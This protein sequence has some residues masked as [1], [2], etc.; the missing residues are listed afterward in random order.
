MPLL[1]ELVSHDANSVSTGIIIFV[2]SRWSKGYATW[3]CCSCDAIGISISIMWCQWH[4]RWHHCICLVKIIKTKCNIGTGIGIKNG[5]TAFHRSRQLK[6][7]ATWLFG[8]LVPLA[9][10]SVLHHVNSITNGTIPFFRLTKIKMQC[11]MTFWSMTALAQV[12]GYMRPTVLS[13]VPLC[14]IDQDD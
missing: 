8:H 5:T 9:M 12:L 1:L 10:V 2:R 3:Y 13:M 11:N 14:F 6:W 7:G 4:H